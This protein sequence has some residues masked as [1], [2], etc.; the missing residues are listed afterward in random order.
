MAYLPFDFNKKKEEENQNTNQ[1]PVVPGSETTQTQ[2]YDKSGPNRGPSK[3]GRFENL[4]SYLTANQ[5]SGLG[6]KIGSKIS[7]TG[8]EAK[9]AISNTET[10]FK[11]QVDAGSLPNYQTAKSDYQNILGKAQTAGQTLTDNDKTRFSELFNNQYK[12][13]KAVVDTELYN[14]TQEK[15]QKAQD[16]YKNSESDA[17]RFALLENYFS[18]PTYTQGQKS[19]DNLILTGQENKDVINQARD[20]LKDVGNQFNSSLEASN[21]YAADREKESSELGQQIRSEIPTYRDNALSTTQQRVN[22]VKS[23]WDNKINSVRN[24]IKAWEADPQF[25][26]AL[27]N[28]AL[29]MLGLIPWD[30]GEAGYGTSLK[31]RLWG[32][33]MK[34]PFS[35]GIKTNDFNASGVLTRDE[36]E[37]IAELDAL[38]QL[39][40]LESKNTYEPNNQNFSLQD[41]LD[42]A[43]FLKL[44]EQG[45]ELARQKYE[46]TGL[47]SDLTNNSKVRR[48]QG[49]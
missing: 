33:D 39:A 13:P 48:L 5:G 32:A 34:T 30:E 10:Q 11:T 14:P 22:Q 47:V 28:D 40:G 18:K 42:I 19:L 44:N 36:Y 26:V 6:Q 49:K 7:D 45:K 24:E 12:G 31:T 23:G 21:K 4:Q 17:G 43:E 1:V 9:N 3:S 25:S 20:S 15:V 41:Y 37:K 2:S 16:L 46:E 27:S 29:G 35:S 8:T 38:A